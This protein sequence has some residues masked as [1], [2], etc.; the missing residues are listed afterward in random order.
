MQWSKK[1][2]KLSSVELSECQEERKALV[3]RVFLFVYFF[4]LA[5]KLQLSRREIL[6][7]KWAEQ[8][9]DLYLAQKAKQ[10]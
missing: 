2:H 5:S 6:F 1:S 10:A 3:Y 7:W 8:T 4:L 9:W